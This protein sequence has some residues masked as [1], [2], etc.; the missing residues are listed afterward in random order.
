MKLNLIAALAAV[1]CIGVAPV[2]ISGC[3][4]QGAASSTS[5]A[6][7][8]GTAP[9]GPSLTQT[10]E[11]DALTDLY[12]LVWD[13][14][15][16]Y[17]PLLSG[18]N[19]QNGQDVADALFTQAATSTGAALAGQLITAAGGSQLAPLATA[20]SSYITTGSLN[21]QD[22]EAVLDTVAAAI[23]DVTNAT[24]TVAPDAASSGTSAA[25]LS[26]CRY[27]R[28]GL[29]F[30][31]ISQG[32]QCSGSAS[33]ET[34]GTGSAYSPTP[35]TAPGYYW[36][37]ESGSSSIVRIDVEPFY[38]NTAGP[39]FTF[40]CG[41]ADTWPLGEQSFKTRVDEYQYQ[42]PDAKWSGPITAPSLATSAASPTPASSGTSAML[43]EE[44]MPDELSGRL[45]AHPRV[46]INP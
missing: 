7:V 1:A 34:N 39:I 21:A 29:A 30:T 45:N 14:A 6:A 12:N 4:N 40:V 35:P 23:Q 22:P 37:T 36:V 19:T 20:V 10:V 44:R 15:E 26:P 31:R 16:D 8:S 46:E 11:S 32:I 43:E 28:R 27:H 42:H 25:I 38:G 17:A 13:A 24:A 5:G 9:A 18:S 2:L 41:E 33:V 3:A